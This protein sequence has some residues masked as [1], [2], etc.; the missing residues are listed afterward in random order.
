MAMFNIFCMF[1]RVH[2]F[3]FLCSTNFSRC[4]RFFSFGNLSQLGP[5]S[6]HDFAQRWWDPARNHPIC[7][8][9]PSGNVN[10]AIENGPLIVDFPLKMVIFHS[11]VTFTRGYLVF[12]P[13]PV[14]MCLYIVVQWFRLLETQEQKDIDVNEKMK[15]NMEKPLVERTS[16]LGGFQRWLTFIFHFSIW[17]VIRNPLEPK[18]VIR[19]GLPVAR[20]KKRA[21]AHSRAPCGATLDVWWDPWIY[22]RG[23]RTGTL[24]LCQNSELENDH[25]NSGFFPLKMVIFHSYVTVYQRVSFGYHYLFVGFPGSIFLGGGFHFFSIFLGVAMTIDFLTLYWR[26]AQ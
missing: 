7:H 17:D 15:I 9:I 6:S 26:C 3:D 4:P 14:W 5:I 13:E 23:F 21:K 12:F 1:T 25:R 20:S 11:F 22:P 24:W 2:L 19:L 18:Q 16:L 10:I 8:K